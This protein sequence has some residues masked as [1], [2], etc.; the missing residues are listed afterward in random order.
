MRHTNRTRAGH[1]AYRITI[2]LLLI[3]LL[4]VPDTASALSQDDLNSIRNGTSFYDPNAVAGCSDTST[5]SATNSDYAGNTILNPAQ[6]AAIDSNK[7]FYQSAAE[8]SGIPWQLIAAIHGRET[9]FRRYGPSNGYGPYQITPSSYPINNS[10]S[11]AE[12]QDATNKAAAFIKVIAGTRD[13]SD[14]TNIKYVMFTYN[15]VAS[16]YINQAKSLG[17]S[18]AQAAVGEG[19]PYVMNRFDLKRDPT[20]APTKDNQTWGQIKTDNGGISYPANGDYGAFV[21]YVAMTGG[22]VASMCGSGTGGST[23]ALN[24]DATA[25][26]SEFTAYMNTHGERYGSYVLGSN[27]CTT[28]SSWFIGEHT[29]LTYGH[30]NGKDVVGNLV[31]VNSGKGLAISSTPKAMSL[32]SIA[33]GVKGW[34]ASGVPEGHVGLVV[35]V[36]EA[37]HTA[38]VVFTG[39][40]K[41]GQ[42]EKA[43]IDT[44]SYP[45]TGVSFV[46]IGDYLK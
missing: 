19:S 5:S 20:V 25:I 35:S 22:T 6:L 34:G 40:K 3:L 36:N 11:D 9:G 10:Y 16:A 15:G 12:F 33:G 4:I 18:D 13:L 30:G 44:F 41:A 23:M 29:T 37:A 43:W 38:I 26:Q 32:V 46:Y 24:G 7:P 31:K 39:A 17:F 28:L 1:L 42:T 27:G 14:P 8:Q 2:T 45:S 21:Y